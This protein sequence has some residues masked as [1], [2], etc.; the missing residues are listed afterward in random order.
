M[1]GAARSRFC[2]WL[3]DVS[4]DKELRSRIFRSLYAGTSSES[5]RQFNVAPQDKDK[6]DSLIFVSIIYI[7]VII[8]IVVVIIIIVVILSLLFYLNYIILF[9]SLLFLLSLTH[10]VSISGCL[11]HQH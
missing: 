7:I 6:I 1:N 2:P 10:N 4:F 3:H 5:A 11:L 8:I 9:L